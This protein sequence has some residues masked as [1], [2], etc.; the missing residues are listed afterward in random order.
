MFELDRPQAHHVR[1]VL[2]LTLHDTL[3]LFDDAGRVAMAT[4]TAT[5]QTRVTVRVDAV[6][7][8]DPANNLSLVIA[9]AVPKGDRAEWMI[10]KLSELGVDRFIPLATARSIV[11]PDGKNKR[12][13]WMRVAIE[14][15]KQSRRQGVMAIAELMPLAVALRDVTESG[16]SVW[17][18]APGAATSVFDV[19][20]HSR[21]VAT[22]SIVLFVGPEGGWTDEEHGIF[23]SANISSL[24]LTQT[25]LRIETAAIAG[26][27]MIAMQTNRDHNSVS[28]APF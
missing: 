6:N 18:L 1:D 4:I 21:D 16:G 2:R 20:T 25:I 8:I 3:E 5:S 14:A 15:A 12:D 22:S 19:V 11:H 17:Y 9:S 23:T 27:A 13:R 10:E 28:F 24:R 7:A 26:A